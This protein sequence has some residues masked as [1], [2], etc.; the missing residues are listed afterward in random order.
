MVRV[1]YEPDWWIHINVTGQRVE[2]CEWLR[3]NGI[4]PVT[5]PIGAEITIE[6]VDGAQ[7]IRHTAYLRDAA[8]HL[9]LDETTDDV[10]QEQRAVPLVTDPPPHWFIKETTR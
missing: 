6:P 4:D 9:Y 1:V 3:A 2:L 10:A 8:G 5:V 7:L